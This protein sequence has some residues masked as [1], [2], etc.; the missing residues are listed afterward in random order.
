MNELTKKQK[1]TLARIISF[2]YENYVWPKELS[3]EDYNIRAVLNELDL[4]SYLP[5]DVQARF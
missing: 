3:D 2:F 4:K 5:L 1:E